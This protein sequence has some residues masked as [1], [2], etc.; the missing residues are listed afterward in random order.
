[1]PSS[2]D[3]LRDLLGVGL[4]E[5]PGSSLVAEIP[6]PEVVINRLIAQALARHEGRLSALH[7]ETG[8][9]NRFVAHVT[10]R[11][12]RLIPVLKV[13]GEIDRQPQFP[14]SP[15]IVVRWSLRNMGPLAAMAAP[16]LSNLKGLPPWISI[17]GDRA[18]IN[19]ADLLR[20]R[21]QGDLVPLIARGEITPRLG[22]AVVR[23]ECR[24]PES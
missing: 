4:E 11:G 8:D 2:L 21:G 13:F 7:I 9:D 24:I 6:I 20:A 17:E 19:L 18:F 14:R 22:H 23:L 12:S 3:R 10:V 15:V 1:M 16:F 5:L